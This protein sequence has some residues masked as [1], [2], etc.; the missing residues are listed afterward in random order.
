MDGWSCRLMVAR[1]ACCWRREHTKGTQLV[2]LQRRRPKAASSRTGVALTGRHCAIRLVRDRT[3]PGLTEDYGPCVGGCIEFHTGSR[4]IIK[5]GSRPRRQPSLY[6]SLGQASTAGRG[7]QQVHAAS[8]LAYRTGG[9]L[10]LPGR[11]AKTS[12]LMLT[13]SRA[14]QSGVGVA[15]SELRSPV[16]RIDEG[17]LLLKGQTEVELGFLV[18]R[19]R[20]DSGSSGGGGRRPLQR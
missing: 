10:N 15:A 19:R 17:A 8:E 7:Q 13:P 4:W 5:R 16:W 18:S 3:S 12:H 14:G 1:F 2:G 9:A 20:T 6:E 11:Y